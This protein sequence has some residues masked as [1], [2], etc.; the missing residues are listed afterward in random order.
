ML[1][2][3]IRKNARDLRKI[4]RPPETRQL[5]KRGNS[6]NSEKGEPWAVVGRLPGGGV[7]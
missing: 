4:T 2:T 1:S 5:N 3:W 7:T 6:R